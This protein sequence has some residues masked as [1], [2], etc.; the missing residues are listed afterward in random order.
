[1]TRPQVESF[2]ERAYRLGAAE[3]TIGLRWRRKD[4]EAMLQ[5]L[6]KLGVITYNGSGGGGD[7]R[8]I[9][10]D[11]FNNAKRTHSL[12]LS[13]RALALYAPHLQLHYDLAH[14]GGA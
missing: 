6:A 4:A 11:A 3:G 2:V 13:Y 7:P 12:K 5:Y 8:V 10:W 14:V 1:M 9:G